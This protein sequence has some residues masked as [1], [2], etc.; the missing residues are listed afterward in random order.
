MV[1]TATAEMHARVPLPSWQKA[2]DVS[3]MDAHRFALHQSRSAMHRRNVQNCKGTMD[4][5]QCEREIAGLQLRADGMRKSRIRHKLEAARELKCENKRLGERITSILCDSEQRHKHIVSAPRTWPGTSNVDWRRR[6]ANQV[7]KD[8]KMML[9]RLQNAGPVIE[10]KGVLQEEYKVHQ[11]RVLRL[12]R[13]KR[14]NVDL[15]TGSAASTARSAAGSGSGATSPV[16]GAAHSRSRA[17]PPAPPRTQP[18][19]RPAPRPK[20]KLPPLAPNEMHTSAAENKSENGMPPLASSSSASAVPTTVQQQHIS[21]PST[22]GVGQDSVDSMEQS[23]PSYASSDVEEV[24][25]DAGRQ[26]T[27]ILG[28][29]RDGEAVDDGV[30]DTVGNDEEADESYAQSNFEADNTYSQFSP[31]AQNSRIL[32]EGG[33]QTPQ[34][35]TSV[36]ETQ[37]SVGLQDCNDFGAGEDADLAAAAL[38][39]DSAAG[40]EAASCKAAEE[41]AKRAAGQVFA[42]FEAECR[43]E[44]E[45]VEAERKSETDCIEMD[46]QVEATCT[47]AEG[48]VE[49]DRLEGERWNCKPSAPEVAIADAD[50]KE[51][52]EEVGNQTELEA[53]SKAVQEI[54]RISAGI[55]ERLCPHGTALAADTSVLANDDSG[56]AKESYQLSQLP[57]TEA[58]SQQPSTEL[59]SSPEDAHIEEPSLRVT[60]PV[61]GDPGKEIPPPSKAQFLSYPFSL[62]LA[63]RDELGV[64]GESDTERVFASGAEF[65]EAALDMGQELDRE[66]PGTERLFEVAQDSHEVCPERGEEFYAPDADVERLFDADDDFQ[67]TCPADPDIERLFASDD[68]LQEGC[69]NTGFQASEG[70]ELNP[71]ARGDFMVRE[72]GPDGMFAAKG[73]FCQVSHGV[74]GLSSDGEDEL[75]PVTYLFRGSEDERLTSGSAT[76]VDK[77]RGSECPHEAEDGYDAG[78]F[79]DF[80][81][82]GD[83]VYTD[84]EDSPQ[85]MPPAASRPQP[86]PTR[87]LAASVQPAKPPVVLNRP[88]ASL[89]SGSDYEA[90]DSFEE[91]SEAGD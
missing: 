29:T 27:G 22:A 63:N 33:E 82:Y 72:A 64:E 67:E 24:S 91:E 19:R 81:E 20:A 45:R 87:P 50:S 73:E 62:G 46:Q 69:L 79:E 39:S 10:S 70:E 2:E 52:E 60:H 21:P 89:S 55:C 1:A 56:L 58:P 80:E 48:K 7:D 26:A 12:S 61:Q 31:S 15:A 54:A 35:S 37:P 25:S 76:K 5:Q 38:P 65:Q 6:V 36:S 53:R 74:Q 43:G 66:E 59:E 30:P 14:R 4:A 88:A 86:V 75:E 41:E 77:D 16:S 90:D 23:W 68:D 47:E 78:D 28:T 85:A 44:V 11:H 49:A 57:S 42:A 3:T 40:I 18:K 8:N 51:E 9:N 32:A 17:H 84:D 83:D 34:A 13:F 71:F